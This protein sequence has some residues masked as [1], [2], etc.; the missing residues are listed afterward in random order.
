MTKRKTRTVMENQKH[1]K[2]ANMIWIIPTTVNST[3]LSGI[4][5]EAKSQNETTLHW[6]IIFLQLPLFLKLL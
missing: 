6:D 2:L 3:D 5:Y 4:N 1:D